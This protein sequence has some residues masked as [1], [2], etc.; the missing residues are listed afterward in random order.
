MP[1]PGFTRPDL[2]SKCAAARRAELAEAVRGGFSADCCPLA[3]DDPLAPL[4]HHAARTL[5]EA[6]ALSGFGYP[7][8]PAGTSLVISRYRGP[9]CG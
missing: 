1:D 4:R 6:G 2:C 8:R 3:G 5:I 7:D 9:L